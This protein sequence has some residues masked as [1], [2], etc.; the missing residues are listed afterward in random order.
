M[1]SVYSSVILIAIYWTTQHHGPED[2]HHYTHCY[3]NWNLILHSLLAQNLPRFLANFFK[4]F[5]FSRLPILSKLPP[6]TQCNIGRAKQ[7]STEAIPYYRFP[8][9]LLPTDWAMCDSWPMEDR[10]GFL[11]RSVKLPA[12]TRNA[13]RTSSS[14]LGLFF[15][16]PGLLF[17]SYHLK[18]T[19]Q[20]SGQTGRGLT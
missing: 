11:L 4:P 15:P 20:S 13:T 2:S 14:P 16:F 19:F 9:S 17:N 18:N 10:C 3:D 12:F 5:L 6:E 1:E 7:Q 8:I